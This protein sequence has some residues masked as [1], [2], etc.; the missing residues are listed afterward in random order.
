VQQQHRIDVGWTFVDIVDAQAVDLDVVRSKVVAGQI[1]ELLVGRAKNID[2]SGP[3]LER[4]KRRPVD[5]HV[6]IQRQALESV[7]DG[8]A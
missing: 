5:M 7:L 1:R 4:P 3:D 8:L 6:L 2:G